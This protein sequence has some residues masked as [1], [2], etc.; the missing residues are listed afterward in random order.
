[1]ATIGLI[2]GGG[3][4]PILFA[5]S[6]RRAGH[7]VIAVAH[8]NETDPALEAAVDAFTWVKLGQIGHVLE[9]L[10]NGGATSTV[11]LGAITKKRFFADAMLDATGTKLSPAQQRQR[12]RQAAAMLLA[13]V[14]IAPIR[15]SPFL[16]TALGFACAM[17]FHLFASPSVFLAIFTMESPSTTVYSHSGRARSKPCI[18]MGSA[19]SKRSC[20]EPSPPARTQRRWKS[21]SNLW[22]SAQSRRGVVAPSFSIS[23][24]REVMR[25]EAASSPITPISTW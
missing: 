11:M 5:E 3:R 21:R 17:R 24:A 6:A 15:T 19:M 18:A 4:F 20:T 9:A 10:R 14:E 22:I 1:M 7:R 8:R 13:N 16:P 25:G 23:S 12:E 2:A